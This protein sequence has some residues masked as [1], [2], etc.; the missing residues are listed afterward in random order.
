MTLP[1]QHQATSRRPRRDAARAPRL[2]PI[3]HGATASHPND[4]KGSTRARHDSRRRARRPKLQRHYGS[5]TLPNAS[6]NRA[7]HKEHL[8]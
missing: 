6:N 7:Q 5:R 1:A 4:V 8:S 2:T 3:S